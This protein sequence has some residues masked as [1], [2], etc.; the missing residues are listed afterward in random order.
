MNNSKKGIVILCDGDFPTRPE[1]LEMLENMEV[2]CC[3]GAAA[4]L[5]AYGVTPHV[6][7]GDMDTLSPA[8]QAQYADLIVRIEEQETNDL[9]KAL[10]WVEQNAYT[11]VHVLGMSGKRED[12]F[13]G[14]LSQCDCW[15]REHPAMQVLAYSDYG[16]F[17][18]IPSGDVEVS[19]QLG[20]AVSLFDWQGGAHISSQ[21]L[22]YPLQGQVL[23]Y[24]FSG[25]LNRAS[26]ELLSLHVEAGSVMLFLGY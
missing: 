18:H 1:L 19:T 21:G 11:E 10:C 14:N 3:D 6:I 7:V 12:H 9:H 8:L 17:M 13:L 23:P 22:D 24:I 25:T 26:G 16:R 4:T 15:S 5:L 2:L 20:Q